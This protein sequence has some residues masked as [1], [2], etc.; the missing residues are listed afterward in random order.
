MILAPF[1]LIA[2]ST[3]RPNLGQ[4]GQGPV[5]TAKTFVAAGRSSG[6][7]G[8]GK[9]DDTEAL[10][11]AIDEALRSHTGLVLEPG[12]YRITRSLVIESD[13]RAYPAGFMIHGQVGPNRNGAGQGGVA[14]ALDAASTTTRALITV[15][16]SH[17]RDMII[18]N[19]GLVS[20]VP[21]NGTPFGLLFAG[22][23]F[24]HATV[25]NLSVTTVH[26]A[27][28]IEK[29]ASGS[30]GEQ[31]DLEDCQG[32]YVNTFY[33]N[34]DGQAYCH[35]V[36][37]CEASLV[38]GAVVFKVGNGLLGFNLDVFGFN[39]S[40]K[41]GPLPN[42][43]LENDGVSGNLNFWGGRNETIDTVLAYTGG[44]PN[45]SGLIL[46]SGI[47]FTSHRDGYP[48]IDATLGHQ[49]N[50]QWTNTFQN[51]MFT[52]FRGQNPKLFVKAQ[53]GD[54]SETFFEKCVFLRFANPIT[55][56]T[57]MDLKIRDCRAAI[58][59]NPRLVDVRN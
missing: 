17:F 16:N 7:V 6:A 45:D 10:Q 21:N 38:N 47:H 36:V 1:L 27:F 55:D 50:Q 42:T 2:S 11:E 14:I 57:G 52:A 49:S 25:R 30:N 12:T 41:D 46:M 29:A 4:N 20:H 9:S 37:N 39:C 22:N 33:S 40:C 23:G 18:E 31:V 5:V 35:H 43:F 53:P 3:V 54:L 48:L 34:N 28:G 19:V 56:A 59:D 44:T 13:I 24:S 15:G 51:C 58:G 8:D 26:T 32:A